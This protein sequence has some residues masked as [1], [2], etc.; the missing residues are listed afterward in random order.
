[1]AITSARLQNFRSHIDSSFEF[2]DGVNI[3]VGPNA[4]GKTNLLDA[5]CFVAI[6]TSLKNTKDKTVNISTNKEWSRVDIIE[7]TNQTRTLKIQPPQQTIIDIEGKI[8]KRLPLTKKIPI[9]M[10]EPNQLYQITSSPDQRR[11]L[12]DDIIS[13]T[14]HSF[15]KLKNDYLRTLIQRNKL[16]KQPNSIIKQ[17]IFAW[18]IRLSELASLYVSKRE[19]MIEKINQTSSNVYSTIANK[20]Y[21]F[22]LRY[23][24]KL[25]TSNYSTA[26]L[27]K[28][29]QNLEIDCLRGFTG[30][31]PHRDDIVLLINNQDIRNIASRGEARSVLLTLKIIE[32]NLLEEL[33]GTK[34]IFLLDDVFGELD[35]IRRKSLIEFIDGGQTFITT[36]DADIINHR[37]MSLANIISLV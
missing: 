21:N 27:S 22:K 29:Q 4:S 12:L 33:Y 34:P 26:M 14:E 30:V 13:K 2:D 19:L 23:S 5:L 10:F 24:S 35:G 6:G 16:L 1:M 7:D 3:I 9:V 18:D 32:A 31:G 37:F 36:T 8:Y 20:N 25:S 11:S 17:Q 28:L 15:N